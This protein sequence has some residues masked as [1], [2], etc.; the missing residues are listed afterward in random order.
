MLKGRVKVTSSWYQ[1]A[2][3]GRSRLVKPFTVFLTKRIYHPKFVPWVRI[4][5]FWGQQHV[6]RTD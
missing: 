4:P 3:S 5:G 2:T 6:G 1:R